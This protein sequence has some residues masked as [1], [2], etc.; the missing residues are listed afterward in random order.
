MTSSPAL[1]RA[2]LRPEAKLLF[3]TAW[4]HAADES[5]VQLAPSVK[6][7]PWFIA[8]TELERAS[9]VVWQRLSSLGVRPTPPESER[10]LEHLS[11]IAAFNAEHLRAR[12]EETLSVYQREGIEVILLKGAALA[13]TIYPSFIERPMG[14]IDV[15]VRP[16]QSERAHAVAQTVGWTWDTA[17]FPSRRYAGHHH[18][19]PL[20]DVGRTGVRL[21]LHT[22]I[23]I[24]GHPFALSF[25]ELRARGHDVRVGTARATVPSGEHLLLHECVHFAW[26]HV[27]S[28]GA[29]RTMR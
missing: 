7:W 14:D 2:P 29:W 28:F 23:A 11:S 22:G 16:E 9:R 5:I 17:Q 6:S 24:D 26:S 3:L 21:E 4:G 13:N 12:L 20:D 1:L 15:L 27:M 25:D 8:L 10:Q 18:L 19:P